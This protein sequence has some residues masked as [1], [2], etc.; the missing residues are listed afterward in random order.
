MALRGSV[1]GFVEFAETPSAAG[2][3]VESDGEVSGDLCVASGPRVWHVPGGSTRQG[4]SLT[5]RLF[6]PFP[7]LA[8]ATVTAVS[9]FGPEPLPSLTGISVPSRN[10]VDLALENELRLRE[11]IAVSITT[12][13]GIVLPVFALDDGNDQ[14]FWPGTGLSTVWEFPVMRTGTMEPA[15]AVVN[16]GKDT[17]DVEI[18]VHTPD[19]AVP[20]ARVVTLAPNEPAR[21]PVGD[22]ADG[23]LGLR[24]RA[25]SP[26][27][28]A[29]VSRGGGA[30]AATPGLSKPSRGWLLPGAGTGREGVRAVWLLNTGAV[31]ATVTLQS[32]GSGP[33]RTDKVALP[34]GTVR[35]FIVEGDEVVGLRADSLE[36]FTAAW[37]IQRSEGAAFSVGTPLER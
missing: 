12:E 21:I 10:W 33:A 9:E 32:L 15:V 35:Q 29:A 6:N 14:A 17:V 18:D 2:V 24:L 25:G 16:P 1:P 19:G 37:S 13:E 22:L 8:K 3:L 23:A 36:P 26:I 27:A 31:D 4:E 34:A 28:A 20:A 5:L 11:A 30:L 7:E